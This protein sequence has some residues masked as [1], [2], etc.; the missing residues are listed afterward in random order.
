VFHSGTLS[1]NPIATA[2]GLA[3]LGE[4]TPDVYIELSA[5]ARR[6]AAVLRDACSAAGFAASFPVV[7]PLVGVV[8]GDVERPVDF[9][10]ARRTDEAAYAALFRSL[11][12]E[13]VAVA[14]GAYE[15]IFAGLAHT[16]A[17]IDEVGDA[18]VRAARTAAA[19]T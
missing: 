15:A 16:D 2:A 9:E 7:G 4:L 19:G 13:G 14:P 5:R 1:G 10:G 11:L 12:R 17:V 8:C 6:L 3:A 18:A